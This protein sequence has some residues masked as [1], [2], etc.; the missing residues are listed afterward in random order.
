MCKE[1]DLY[2]V[3]RRELLKVFERGSDIVDYICIL[4]S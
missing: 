2:P 4:G 3:S 1:V